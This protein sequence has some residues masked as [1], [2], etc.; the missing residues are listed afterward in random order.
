MNNTIYREELLDHYQTPRNFKQLSKYTHS[1]AKANPLCGD[2]LNFFLL[3]K[4]NRL[5]DIGFQGEGC[6]I[7]MATASILS[8]YFKGQKTSDLLNFKTKELLK[9]LQIQLTPT[10]LK[11]ALLPLET[12]QSAI[13]NK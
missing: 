13:L 11:C 5:Q 12:I 10:R 1:A 2:Q 3:I 6:V 8:E 4:N 9:K 7:S